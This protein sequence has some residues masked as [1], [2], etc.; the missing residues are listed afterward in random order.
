[1][2][3]LCSQS[4]AQSFLLRL[5]HWVTV[6]LYVI[7]FLLGHRSRLIRDKGNL[8]MVI[9]SNKVIF[10]QAELDCINE[11][12]GRLF[13]LFDG[14]QSQLDSISDM[15]EKAGVESVWVGFYYD[16]I[17]NTYHYYPGEI[18]PK[19]FMPRIHM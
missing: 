4:E 13:D 11:H 1:M 6:R 2:L 14:T 7:I 15:M 3:L 16:K 18:V 5:R 12:N 17:L 8:E 9:I 10:R 19:E